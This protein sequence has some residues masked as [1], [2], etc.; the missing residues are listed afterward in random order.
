MFGR[1]SRPTGGEPAT[2]STAMEGRCYTLVGFDAG[3]RLRE[4]ICSMGL[5][6]GAVITVIS[7][8]GHG[9]IGVKVKRTR[10]GI[11]RGM[12]EKIRVRAVAPE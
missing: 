12:A 11:G 4:R 9:P 7:N 6:S 8:S 2:L 5:N 10:L 1:S 3:Q